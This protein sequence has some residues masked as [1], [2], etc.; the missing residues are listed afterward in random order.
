MPSRAV[1]PT[2]TGPRPGLLQRAFRAVAAVVVCA[3]RRRAA[4]RRAESLPR[5]SLPSFFATG[6]FAGLMAVYREGE[7]IVRP[8]GWRLDRL[9]AR[10][11]CDPNAPNLLG[12]RPSEPASL[13][14][15][16]SYPEQPP[17]AVASTP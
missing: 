17:A 16:H 5:W 10:G 4:R 14:G 8:L 15:A 6:R 3:V 7:N 12:T 13:Q 2:R 1:P 9:R 11:L